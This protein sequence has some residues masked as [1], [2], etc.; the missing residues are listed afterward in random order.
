[1]VLFAGL[2]LSGALIPFMASADDSTGCSAAEAEFN[3]MKERIA[4]DFSSTAREAVQDLKEVNSKLESYTISCSSSPILPDVWAYSVQVL[5]R[6]KTGTPKWRNE[7]RHAREVRDKLRYES[8]LFNPAKSDLGVKDTPTPPKPVRKKWA[9]VVGINEFVDPNVPSLQYAAKDASDFADFLAD[10]HGGGFPSGRV[11]RLINQQATGLKIKEGIGWLRS[12]AEE[13]DLVVL[14]FSSHGSPRKSDPNGVSY[15]ITHDTSTVDSASLYATSIQMVDLVLTITRELKAKRVVLI[16]DTCYS[17][18]AQSKPGERSIS[19]VYASDATPAQFSSA[20]SGLKIGYG[21]AVLTASRADETSL[22]DKDLD[23]GR[24][25]GYFTRFLIDA[26]RER[27]S[28]PALDEK[29]PRSL[30]EVFEAVQAKVSSAVKT[31]HPTALFSD[32]AGEI[33]LA[34]P[35]S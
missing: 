26:L 23:G 25:N 29:L 33:V 13:D 5:E 30:D 10:A 18:D 8:L 31:Q 15:I 24:G 16:L 9:L 34:V 17:G 2:L 11:R 7:L 14:Y 4:V 35:E 27:V 6:L 3:G 1:M 21:R 28:K 12:N 22:E 19:P 20:L 32:H